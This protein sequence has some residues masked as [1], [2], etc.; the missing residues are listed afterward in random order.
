MEHQYQK[1]VK[2]HQQEQVKRISE[3]R[4]SVENEKI[5]PMELLFIRD[6][7]KLCS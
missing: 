4:G 2:L 3:L 5:S 1:L 6:M 7:N